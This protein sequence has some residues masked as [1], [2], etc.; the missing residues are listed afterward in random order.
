[1]SKLFRD[2]NK[3]DIEVYRNIEM[4]LHCQRPGA[5]RGNGKPLYFTEQGH[6][7][8]C[9]VNEIIKKYDKTGLITHVSNFEA[10]FGDMT[11][12]DFKQMQDKVANAKS[13]FNSLP[14]EIRDYF[15][16]SPTDL[17][18]FMEDPNNRE[19]GIELGLIREDFDPSKDGFGEHVKDPDI[20][21]KKKEEPQPAEEPTVV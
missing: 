21:A 11:G 18:T 13:M 9:D 12:L 16:N 8:D 17:L 10:K 5:K 1:M 15:R 7:K 6:K 2:K 4:R 19:K 20:D 3:I 14:A